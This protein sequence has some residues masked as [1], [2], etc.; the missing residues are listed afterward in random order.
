MGKA[1]QQFQLR[2]TPL[3]APVPEPGMIR[4]QQRHPPLA[5]TI[6]HKQGTVIRPGHDS[7]TRGL[8]HLDLPHPAA[9]FPAE[10]LFQPGR[11]R[12]TLAQVRNR[13]MKPF[14][15]DTRGRP[16]GHDRL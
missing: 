1:P 14:L 16:R 7:I 4:G 5:H 12:M 9:P 2:A 15:D 8:V 11:D 6:Q 3:V 10:F 13:G